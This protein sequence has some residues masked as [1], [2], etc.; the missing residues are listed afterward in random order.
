MIKN[1]RFHYKASIENII[2]DKQR[3]MDQLKIHW[4]AEC[5]YIEKNE[6]VLMTGST[7]VGKIYIATAL[8][9]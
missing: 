7:G 4:L 6:N 2:Y 1:A 5:E 3:K 9:Y 8:G